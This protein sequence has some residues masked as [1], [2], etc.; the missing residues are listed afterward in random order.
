MQMGDERMRTPLL[1][2]GPGV[3][4]GMLHF[5]PLAPPRGSRKWRRA[6]ALVEAVVVVPVLAIIAFNA[7]EFAR[8]AQVRML[9][10][11]AQAEGLRECSVSAN[12][13]HN[14]TGN[15]DGNAKAKDA[16]RAA[17]GPWSGRWF[18]AVEPPDCDFK[19]ATGEYAPV[20]FPLTA[21]YKCSYPLSFCHLMNRQVQGT[22]GLS[23]PMQTAYYAKQSLD[24]Y[25][26]PQ[27]P[28]QKGE[29]GYSVDVHGECVATTSTDA[30]GGGGPVGDGYCQYGGDYDNCSACYANCET[31]INQGCTDDTCTPYASCKAGCSQSYPYPNEP[32]QT[33]CTATETAQCSAQC[34]QGTGGV[35]ASLCFSSCIAQCNN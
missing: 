29:S 35:S 30:G 8:Y 16:A 34:A 15:A 22:A 6:A 25:D 3:R 31:M 4:L 21:D 1:C 2:W 18:D 12:H 32:G 19:G 33:G 14:P 10:R 5:G 26:G 17:L 7:L 28:C 13:L 9:V 20:S 11:Y 23:M 27:T 24:P